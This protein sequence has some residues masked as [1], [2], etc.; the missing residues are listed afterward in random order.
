MNI[1]RNE[2]KNNSIVKSSALNMLFFFEFCNINLQRRHS[3]VEQL[4]GNH[5]NLAKKRAKKIKIPN[6]KR[7]MTNK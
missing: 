3:V 6:S 7:Q 1:T 5:L 2:L 4:A